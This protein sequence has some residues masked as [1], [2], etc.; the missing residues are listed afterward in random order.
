MEQTTKQLFR[1]A[2]LLTIAGLISKIISAGYRIPLQNITGDLGFYMYQQVYPIL[3]ISLTLS[4]YGFPA[5]ISKLVASRKEEGEWLSVRSFYIPLFGLLFFING[6]L[7]IILYFGSNKIAAWMGDPNLAQA[8]RVA[9]FPFLLVPFTSLFR[10]VSQGLNDMRPTATSQV[11]EQIIRVIVILFFAVI[12][13]QANGDLYGVAV[14]AGIG[15]TIAAGIAACWLAWMWLRSQE[16]TWQK[17]SFSWR[18]YSQTI[19]GYG[20]FICLNYM[21]LLLLQLADSLTVV[22]GLIDHGL[23]TLGAKEWKGVLDRGYPLV[24]LG[25]VL[26]SSLALALIPSVTKKRYQRAPKSFQ[27]HME[28]ALRFSIYIA[29]ACSFGLMAIMPLANQM[30]YE[31]NEGVQSLQVLAFTI[32]FASTALTASSI[33]QGLGFIYRTAVFVM[34][35]FFIKYIGNLMFIPQFG[36]M[37]SALATVFAVFML[38]MINVYVLKRKVAGIRWF[39]IPFARFAISL[40]IMTGFVFAMNKVYAYSPFL[41]SRIETALFVVFTCVL[42]AFLYFVLLIRLHALEESDLRELPFA[43]LLIEI[44]RWRFRP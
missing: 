29:S 18:T 2:L 5:A 4:L 15:A 36:I 6:I 10:G 3:G 44:Q 40:L 31:T 7:F 23:P 37:G 24:Q 39:P 13:V 28:S 27:L 9:A 17:M 34:I 35:A 25:T 42:A 19:F 22:N 30:L 16:F 21:M 12:V 43:D 11:L 8:F 38:C 41:N 32:L 26:G 33:L 20:F 1:G 14:G